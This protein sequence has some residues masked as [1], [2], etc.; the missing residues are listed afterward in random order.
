MRNVTA[1]GTVPAPRS[2]VWAVLADYPNIVDWNRA[3]KQS[4]AIGDT[5]EGVGAQRQVNVGSKGSIRNRETVT[6]WEP[7]HRMVIAVDKIEKQPISKAT[8]TF[9]LSDADG[10]TPFW[11]RGNGFDPGDPADAGLD[12]DGDGLDNLGEFV[13][14][15]DPHDPD[16][17]RD[18][19]EDGAEASR[20]TNPL[21]ADTDD[22]GLSDGDEVAANPF[23]TDPLEPDTDGDGVLD[24][25]ELMVGSD[26]SDGTSTGATVV[27][28]E[29]MASNGFT[30]EDEDGENSDWIELVN[31]TGSPVDLG[32]L[33]LTDDAG[34][35][36][37]WTFPAGVVLSPSGFLVVFASGKDRAVQGEELH[38]NFE[39]AAGGEY[40]A[41]VA[42][43]GSTVLQEFAP[44]FP[45][46]ESDVSFDGGGL[47]LAVPT[48]G[49]VNSAEGVAGFVADTKFSV[50]RGFYAAPITVEITTSTPEV[51]IIYTTDSTTPSMQNGV[52]VE[53]SLA[54]VSIAATTVLRAM[55]VK[56][57]LAPTNVDT[58]TYVF[59]ADVVT[60]SDNPADYEYPVW[61]NLD[62]ARTADYGMDQDDI[63]G[64]LYSHQEVID[65]LRSLPSISIATDAEKLFD[66]ETGNYA[67]SRRSGMAWEREISMEFFGFAHGRDTQLNGGLRLAGNASRSP[68]R[69]KHNMRVAFRREYGEGTLDFPL[70]PDSKVRTF[71]SIQLRGGNGDSWVNPGVRDRGTYIRDQWHRD[72]HR[73]MGGPSQAQIYAH[74]YINGMYW[75]VYHV[76]ERIEDDYLVQHVGGKGR[77]LG[78]AGSCFGLRRDRGGLAA[79]FRDCRRSAG[80][81]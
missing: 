46:Q 72:V 70:F 71:N 79:G 19:L 29:F 28:S 78:R 39:L 34:D 63:V 18:G 15:T 1:T 30:L 73:A 14:G 13:A 58:H 54:R 56:E 22:D 33:F 7:E 65:S 17:D 76:F 60:Q 75:G 27:I 25:V 21:T 35:L 80:N 55:A 3:V 68:N 8:M 49:A 26:P 5:V 57:G 2:S 44:E 16:S 52:Q 12:A 37:K 32:G 77:G 59:P 36:T 74:L 40:L 50:D 20:G 31:A 6:Q 10:T 51:T 45:R 48:P 38:A 69:H 47:Y 81:G 62:Q 67:N 41:L 53:G 4:Y 24:P 64:V 42:A 61:D 11:E 43:D 66:R 23:V 9:T